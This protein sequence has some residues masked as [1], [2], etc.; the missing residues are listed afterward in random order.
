MIK[1]ERL[2]AK[3]SV[4]REEHS[5]SLQH[6]H[7]LKLNKYDF[8][9]FEFNGFVL[10]E[11]LICTTTPKETL[12]TA[13]MPVNKIKIFKIHTLYWFYREIILIITCFYISAI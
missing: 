11:I 2:R 13:K 8:W 1:D 6:L 3:D 4:T 5:P 10:I 9:S 12:L 7:H